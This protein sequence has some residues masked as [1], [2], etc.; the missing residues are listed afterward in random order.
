MQVLELKVPPVVVTLAAAL[1]MW[2]LTR[3]APPLETGVPWRFGVAACLFGAGLAVG[4]AGV[5]SIRRARTTVN[6]VRPDS[7]SALVS[8]GIYGYSRNP[9]Y[10]GLLLGLLGWAAWLGQLLTLP[11][12]PGFV[13][14]MNRFQIRPEERALRQLFG[15]QFERYCGQVGRW[16]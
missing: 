15:E 16:L 8:T 6:P 5:V 11:V 3:L 9:M 10:L 14:Y 2:G 12:L 13:L 7:A 4:L 1:L